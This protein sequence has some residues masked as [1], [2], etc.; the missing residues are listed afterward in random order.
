MVAGR[1]WSLFSNEDEEE[2]KEE[3]GEPLTASSWL[4]ADMEE[5][6]LNDKEEEEEEEEKEEEEN[7]EDST[8]PLFLTLFMMPLL[9]LDFLGRL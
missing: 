1:W 2:D 6:A 3:E 4:H 8:G 7:E 5:A 9:H